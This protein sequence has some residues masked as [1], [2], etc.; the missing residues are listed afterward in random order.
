[1]HGH[2][3]TTD[4]RFAVLCAHNFEFPRV[5]HDV[6]KVFCALL[7]SFFFFFLRFVCAVTQCPKWQF[8]L[9]NSLLSS[10]KHVSCF[11]VYGR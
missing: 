5:L 7:R 4:I 3:Q 10:L 2:I 6:G 8:F 9:M 1:V 11:P